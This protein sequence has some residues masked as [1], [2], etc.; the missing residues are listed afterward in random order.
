MEE[1]GA[2][3]KPYVKKSA[4]AGP[5]NLPQELLQ[6]LSSFSRREFFAFFTLEQVLRHLRQP[7]RR[8]IFGE[9]DSRKKPGMREL[10]AWKGAKTCG[11]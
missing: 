4:W 9:R 7:G 8:P 6:S 11:A 2:F 5:E 3:D 10:R 1:T